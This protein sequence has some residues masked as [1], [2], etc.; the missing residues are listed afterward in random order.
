[1]MSLMPKNVYIQSFWARGLYT[2]GDSI[3]KFGDSN[4]SLS[5]VVTVIFVF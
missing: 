4:S 5:L 3:L 2:E 1:M